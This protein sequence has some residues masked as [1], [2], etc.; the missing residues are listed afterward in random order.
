MMQCVCFSMRTLFCFVLGGGGGQIDGFCI[1]E[2]LRYYGVYAV[3]QAQAWV[4][5][6]LAIRYCFRLSAYCSVF[7]SF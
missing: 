2:P 5:P 4:G 7:S 3:A 6:G 1:L